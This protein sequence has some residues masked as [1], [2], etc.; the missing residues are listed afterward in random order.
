MSSSTTI[1]LDTP[2]FQTQTV[3]FAYGSNMQLEQM[4]RRCPDSRY[5]GRGILH[6]YKWQINE[7]GVANIY[8]SEGNWVEG[9]CFLL[10]PDDEEVLDVYEGVSSSIYLKKNMDL[11]VFPGNVLVVGR[12]TKEV[13]EW[14]KSLEAGS[15]RMRGMEGDEGKEVVECLVYVSYEG[16]AEDGI[17]RRGYAYAIKE[18]CNDAAKLGVT[19]DYYEKYIVPVFG[20]GS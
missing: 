14:V 3:Y 10:S 7:R 9:L 4:T 12:K 6:N 16:K 18:G 2:A 20:D 13:E 11:D 15:K 8:L 19:R 5:L 17:A 1:N